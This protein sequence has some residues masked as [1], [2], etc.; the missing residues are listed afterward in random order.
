MFLA[1]QDAENVLKAVQQSNPGCS[2][3]SVGVVSLADIS[4]EFLSTDDES[5]GLIRFLPD[6]EWINHIQD[7]NL[8]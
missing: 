4:G 8:E 6:S 1:K 2:D 3:V 7:L 5:F